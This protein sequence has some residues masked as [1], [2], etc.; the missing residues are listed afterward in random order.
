MVGNVDNL[1]T[2]PE[3]TNSKEEFL[4]MDSFSQMTVKTKLRETHCQ[5]LEDPEGFLE[6]GTSGSTRDF[7]T[8]SAWFIVISVVFLLPIQY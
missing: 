2:W 1:P 4:D 6:Q 7:I 8:T 3:H 5:F